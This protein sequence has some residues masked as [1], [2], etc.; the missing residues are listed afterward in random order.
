MTINALRDDLVTKI[1]TVAEVAD[2]TVALYD[3]DALLNKEEKLGLP[4]VGVVYVTTRG[5][6][7]GSKSGMAA[8]VIFDIYVIGGSACKEDEEVVGVSTLLLLDSVRD[9]IKCTTPVDASSAPIA[10]AR[11]KWQFMMEA[12]I[13]L[14]GCDSLGYVQRWK[15]TLLLT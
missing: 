5:A 9:A 7:D 1:Q 2:S 11:R 3:Q 8:T 12:P 14:E 4:C 15:T 10:Q 6:D 13:E